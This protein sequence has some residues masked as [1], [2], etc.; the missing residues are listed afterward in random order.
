MKNTKIES[1]SEEFWPIIDYNYEQIRFAEI[2]ASVI[3]VTTV[4]IYLIN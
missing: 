2:K 4:N 1:I 3:P